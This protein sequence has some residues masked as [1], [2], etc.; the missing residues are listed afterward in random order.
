M[1][2]NGFLALLCLSVAIWMLIR[3]KSKKLASWLMLIAGLFLGGLI[4]ELMNTG[5]AA[6]RDTAGGALGG[7]VGVGAGAVMTVIGVLVLLELWHGIH[8]RKG[9]PSGHHPFLALAAPT[10]LLAA[11]GIFARIIHPLASAANGVGSHLTT[12]IGR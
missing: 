5:I 6:I 8:P 7:L 4:G 10:L 1:I 2:G 3:K 12:L 11:G 9:S